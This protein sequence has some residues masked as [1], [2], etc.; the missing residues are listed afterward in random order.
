MI[1]DA[2]NELHAAISKAHDSLR[3]ELSRLRTGRANPE[4]LDSIRIDYYGTPT[5]IAQMAS[6]S[7]PEARMI[8]IKPWDKS[9]IALIEKAIA[10]SPIE[11]NPQNDGEIIRLPI[12]SLTEE[13]R[14]DLVKVARDHGEK[15]K[16]AIRAA[17]HDAKDF[18]ESLKKE[19]DVGEDEADRAQKKVESIVQDGTGK[20]DEIIAKK[21]K[22]IMEI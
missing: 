11:L 13:R 17:R 16:V 7:V 9:S 2:I 20:T 4:V 12:P 22:D 14:K 15:C 1:D 3:K 18:I 21:E 6:V 5:P 8:V 10:A 19:G